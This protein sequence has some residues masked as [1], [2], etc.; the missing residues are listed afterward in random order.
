MDM[1][2]ATEALS[3]VDAIAEGRYDR[4][5]LSLHLSVADRMRVLGK[6]VR[7]ETLA[8][9]QERERARLADRGR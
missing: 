3:V 2:E 8:Q 7:E 6:S 9:F 4:F 1:S 5:L